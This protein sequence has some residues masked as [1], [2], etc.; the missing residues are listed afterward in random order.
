MTRQVINIHASCA[1][2]GN[3]SIVGVDAKTNEN[4]DETA[5][6]T[7]NVNLGNTERAGTMSDVCSG[8]GEVGFSVVGA[9]FLCLSPWLLP[10]W[11]VSLRA[12][13]A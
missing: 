4:T 3:L 11:G 12:L 8:G 2:Q 9:Y 6:G 1:P 10:L 13:E 7:G 5:C